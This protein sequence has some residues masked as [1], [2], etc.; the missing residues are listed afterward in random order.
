[1][2]KFNSQKQINGIV[3]VCLTVGKPPNTSLLCILWLL[4]TAQA[5]QED[6]PEST[7]QATFDTS[8]DGKHF[9]FDALLFFDLFIYLYIIY[10]IW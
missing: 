2:S 6:T 10:F 9:V 7:Y 8:P 1:M 4:F 3:Q 5:D